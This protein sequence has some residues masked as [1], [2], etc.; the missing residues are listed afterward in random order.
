MNMVAVESCLAVFASVVPCKGIYL[1]T[2]ITSGRQLLQCSL[3]SDGEYSYGSPEYWDIINKEVIPNN[4]IRGSSFAKKMRKI[5]SEPV[6]DPSAFFHCSWTQ[7]DY[8]YLW[9]QVITTYA[10]EVWFNEH[11]YYSSGCV[12]EY[13]VTLRAG[14][15][16]KD[17]LGCV[18][19]NADANALISKAITKLDENKIPT[20]RLTDLYKRLSSNEAAHV[21]ERRKT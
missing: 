6:I 2:P 10:K 7:K 20:R 5:T 21:I 11:W 15:S 12:F 8:L 19:S 4:C 14:I 9:E 3:G 1:S 16:R 18:L 17:H 13:W